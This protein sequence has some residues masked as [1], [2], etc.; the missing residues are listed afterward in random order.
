MTVER[1][2]MIPV[3]KNR[4]T[5]IKC[6]HQ[7]GWI[8][9]CLGTSMWHTCG[10]VCEGFSRDDWLRGNDTVHCSLVMNKSR[11][12]QK[13][14]GLVLPF[15]CLLIYWGLS[16]K[17]PQ[18]PFTTCLYAFTVMKDCIFSN[19]VE[20]SPFPLKLLLACMNNDTRNL[21]KSGLGNESGWH[22]NGTVLVPVVWYCGIIGF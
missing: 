4:P 21:Y 12:G 7:L 3:D 17:L 8:K 18:V 13:P 22:Q 9:E 16:K 1:G 11:K 10:C 6:D 5:M 14:A 15:F 2:R 20:V 19:W